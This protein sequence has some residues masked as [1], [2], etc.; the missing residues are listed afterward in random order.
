MLL[1]KVREGNRIIGENQII[2]DS[3]VKKLGKKLNSITDSRN[4][5]RFMFWALAAIQI[6]CG[7]LR[8]V[9]HF[10]EH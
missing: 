6:V 1:G 9:L 8:I 10:V 5:Y 4:L 2:H 3:I 7:V